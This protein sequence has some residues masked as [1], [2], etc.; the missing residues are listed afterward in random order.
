MSYNGN[1]SRADK[2]F[3]FGDNEADDIQ[4]LRSFE[5]IKIN[6]LKLE[7]TKED[8]VRLYD[9]VKDEPKGTIVSFDMKGFAQ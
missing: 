8:I 1:K 5:M 6:Y 9:K 4:G 2:G 7:L 3:V